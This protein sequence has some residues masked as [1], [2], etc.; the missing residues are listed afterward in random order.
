[1]PSGIFT[2]GWVCKVP[3]D[4]TKPPFSFRHT[5]ACIWRAALTPLFMPYGLKP[6]AQATE[7][8][9][10]L[11]VGSGRKSTSVGRS[12]SGTPQVP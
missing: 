9:S 4:L 7:V 6:S 3:V 8:Y 11:Y 1:M 12:K 5:F 10:T 2:E